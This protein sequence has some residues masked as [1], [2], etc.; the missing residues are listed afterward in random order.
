M[1]FD[2]QEVSK[3]SRAGRY[4]STHLE[5]VPSLE[6][7]LPGIR[8]EGVL[9]GESAEP[10]AT[11]AAEGASWQPRPVKPTLLIGLAGVVGIG[12]TREAW[13]IPPAC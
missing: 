4:P 8:L 13:R 10:K 2:C 1:H 9:A 11:K 12:D 3:R 6:R 5:I 7:S